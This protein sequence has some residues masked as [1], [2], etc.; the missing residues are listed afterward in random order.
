MTAVEAQLVSVAVVVVQR[1]QRVHTQ[2]RVR[3]EHA[4]TRSRRQRCVV[5]VVVAITLPRRVDVTQ[6]SCT[7]GDL[8]ATTTEIE[9]KRTK[10]RNNNRDRDR[11]ETDK[12]EEQEQQR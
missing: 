8:L 11:E 9:R 3:V 2:H 10:V 12:G 7:V 1:A 6:R 5:P 4:R